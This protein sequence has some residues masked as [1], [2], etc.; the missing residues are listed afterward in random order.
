M[1]VR[2]PRCGREGR[3][4]SGSPRPGQAL[5]SRA[6]VRPG[7]AGQPPRFVRVPWEDGISRHTGVSPSRSILPGPDPMSPPQAF[8]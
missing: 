8:I 1:A 6:R 2:P 5:C 3:R 7:A 4:P